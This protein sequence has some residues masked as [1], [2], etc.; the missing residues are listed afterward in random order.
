MLIQQLLIG[1]QHTKKDWKDLT[2]YFNEKQRHY[3]GKYLLV[4]YLLDEKNEVQLYEVQEE[5]SD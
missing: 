1:V 2:N 3:N 4:D 5:E